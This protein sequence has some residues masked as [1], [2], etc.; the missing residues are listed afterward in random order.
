[1]SYFFNDNFLRLPNVL[2]YGKMKAMH[3]WFLKKKMLGPKKFCVENCN[4]DNYILAN[5]IVS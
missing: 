1:M 2:Y 3:W 4:K 5:W